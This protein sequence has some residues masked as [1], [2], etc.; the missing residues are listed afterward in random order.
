[1][2]I[3]NCIEWTK[4]ISKICEKI[5]TRTYCKFL[6]LPLKCEL[7]S[8]LENQMIREMFSHCDENPAHNVGGKYR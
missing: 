4:Q 7:Q 8:G 3:K 5:R 6:L 1:M 2:K